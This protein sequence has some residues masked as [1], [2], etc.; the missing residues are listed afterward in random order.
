VSAAATSRGL[1]ACHGCGALA[2]VSSRRTR[3]ELRCPRCFEPMHARKPHSLQR[4]WT[5]TIA[6]AILYEPANLLPIMTAIQY[7]QGDP[8]TIMSG[9]VALF[10][11][12]QPAIA[13]LVFVASIMV[14]LLKLVGLSLL[15][16]SVQFG[17][18]G[19]PRDRTVLYRIV[20]LVG[21]WSMLDIF[22]ISLMVALMQLGFLATIEA[23]PGALCFTSVVVLTM[24]AAE[25]FDPR[26]IWDAAGENA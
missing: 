8:D 1:L 13:I 22:I 16:L 19:R 26:L 2:R 12:G 9:V 18:R 21:R 5:L 10:R 24:L 25:S 7:G 20:E 17:W 6:A 14:P 11:T 4:T 15:M 23:G 3:T